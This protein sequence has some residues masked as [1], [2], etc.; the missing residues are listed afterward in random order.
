M[1]LDEI[2]AGAARL[3]ELEA[4]VSTQ[5]ALVQD[6]IRNAHQAGLR[7]KL[8]Q[9]AAGVSKQWYYYLVRNG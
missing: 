1:T 3:A 9:E 7:P 2:R 6:A 4:Q 8:V 5:R